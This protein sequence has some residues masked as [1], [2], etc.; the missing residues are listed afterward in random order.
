MHHHLRD[1][2]SYSVSDGTVIFLDIESD[3]YFR[4]SAPLERLFVRYIE[5]DEG[6]EENILPLVE[7][8]MLLPTTHNSKPDSSPSVPIPTQSTVEHSSPRRA[9]TATLV[10]EVLFTTWLID[11][12][13]KTRPLKDV[14]ARTCRYRD[15]R[16]RLAQPD[17][18]SRSEEWLVEATSRFRRAR[19]H[20]PIPTRCLL[21]SLSL[22]RFLARRGQASSIVFGVT[23][24]P[25][26]AHCWLQS[27]EVV[28]ND[29]VGN[30]MNHI[31]IR[32]I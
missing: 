17:A 19:L 22:A 23:H 24:E 6:S 31:P 28:L 29:T 10:P 11:R 18:A 2:L 15:A 7:R 14:L 4:L 32:V 30:V 27:G 13:L 3:Q 21:D 9:I 12:Q 1:G 5:D 26:R 25:F 20:V 16:L 8:G